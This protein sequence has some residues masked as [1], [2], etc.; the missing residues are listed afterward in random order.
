MS[1]GSG[2][3]PAN[4]VLLGGSVT[5]VFVFPVFLA[6]AMAVQLAEELAF[7]ASRLGLAIGAFRGMAA[8]LS[9]PLGR[10]VD[11]LGA[12]RSLRWA[13]LGA[14]VSTLGV[15]VAA[16]SWASL[17]GWL[18]VGGAAH[19]LG[20][21]AAN[22]LISNAVPRGRLG[23]AFGLKQSAP[24][25][26]AMLAG[27]SVSAIA[28]TVGWRWAYV[29]GAVMAFGVAIAVQTQPR[30]RRDRTPTYQ[31]TTPSRVVSRR[32]IIALAIG[33]G[34]GTASSSM[35]TAFYVTGAVHAG[36]SAQFAGTMLA[37]S[38]LV[39]VVGRVFFGALCDTLISRPLRLCS[40]LLLFGSLGAVWLAFG[41]LAA[42]T[43]GVVIAI[44]GTWGF[45]GIFWFAVVR[46]HPV[47]PGRITGS[48]APGGLL[49]GTLGP[50]VFG[51]VAELASYPSAWILC[52]ASAVIAGATIAISGRQLDTWV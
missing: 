47:S 33:F 5:V 7:G 3:S 42:A 36:A 25:V 2:R 32:V 17:V 19:A 8:F 30:L 6:G 13:A 34:F 23:L 28:Q 18:L 31:N 48:I 22:R 45:N 35:V 27:L 9:P 39:A 43:I 4:A 46:A 1:Q 49:G 41:G 10:L 26:A 40:S 15:A 50:V 16:T 24:P 14:G 11:R 38:S 37:V 20:Q 21:P 12:G 52:A 44:V 29:L 51:F